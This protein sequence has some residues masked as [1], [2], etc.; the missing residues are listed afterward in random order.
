MR[1]LGYLLGRSI[2]NFFLQLLRKPGRLAGYLVVIA[3]LLLVL[4]SSGL[5]EPTEPAE[6]RPMNELYAVVLSLY[7]FGLGTGVKKG[8]STGGTFFSMA[9]VNLLFESPLSPKQILVYGLVR[10]AGMTV[11]MGAVLLFQAATLRSLYGCGLEALLLIFGGFVLNQMAGELLAVV[12]YGV[13]SGNEPRR[14]WIRVL[15]AVLLAPLA[16]GL[17][18]QGVVQGQ[19]IDAVPET[20]SSFLAELYPFSG[21]LK[22]CVR[23]LMEGDVLLFWVYLCAFLLLFGAL[24]FFLCLYR[25]DYYEDVL[26]SSEEQANQ[27]EKAKAGAVAEGK[28]RRSQ[29]AR[30]TGRLKGKKASALLYRHLLENRRT[31]FWMFDAMSFMQLGV[32]LGFLLIMKVTLKEEGTPDTLMLVLLCFSAYLQ[33]FT[34]G[35]GRWCKEL[36]KQFIYLIPDSP[37]RKL[38]YACGE[39]VWKSFLE[40]VLLFGA[41]GLLAGADL[42]SVLACI[43]TRTGL[44]F[45]FIA[46]NLLMERLFGDMTSKGLILMLYFLLLFLLMA[47]GVAAGLFLSALCFGELVFVPALLFDTLVNLLL[48][49][50]ILAACRNILHWMDVSSPR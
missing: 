48:S 35:A 23:C 10:Q 11:L 16:V 33:M 42:V 41:G 24:V 18:W 3:L 29:Q 44:T 9:D 30:R 20:L 13:S 14:K 2:R 34:T 25:V 1:A 39:G 5:Q 7:L 17:L 8:L 22:G 47:P 49:A 38:A 21:W 26:L 31:G 27:R 4:V 43:L 15:S 6:L 46:C 28:V 19:G 32:G 36:T 12:I 40:G 45:L 50:L 37:F